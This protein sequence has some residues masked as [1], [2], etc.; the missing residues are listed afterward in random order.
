MFNKKIV[1]CLSLFVGLWS[2]AFSIV[3]FEVKDL[4]LP[5]NINKCGGIQVNLSDRY[6]YLLITREENEFIVTGVTC[7]NIAPVIFPFDQNEK[8]FS[9]NN[10]LSA[11][12]NS[13]HKVSKKEYM[14]LTEE[15]Y[16]L[17]QENCSLRYWISGRLK[18]YRRFVAKNTKRLSDRKYEINLINNQLLELE[19]AQLKGDFAVLKNRT[20]LVGYHFINPNRIQVWYFLDED[21]I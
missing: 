16:T 2:S 12:Y 11:Q 17:I 3:F 18:N 5:E 6:S 4:D 8:L 19:E 14:V 21:D 9:N 1:L 7:S 15:D 10:F 20:L 13:E